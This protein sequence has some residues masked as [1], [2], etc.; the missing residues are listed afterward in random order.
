MTH[1]ERGAG[2]AAEAV[3]G[4]AAARRPAVRWCVGGCGWICT[5]C[6]AVHTQHSGLFSGHNLLAEPP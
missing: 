3:V 5:E 4:L 1:G 2:G 6:V